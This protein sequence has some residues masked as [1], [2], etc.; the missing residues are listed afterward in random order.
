MYFILFPFVTMIYFIY[1]SKY[2][3]IMNYFISLAFVFSHLK[4]YIIVI[5][6]SNCTL[7]ELLL[8]SY[9]QISSRHREQRTPLPVLLWCTKVYICTTIYILYLCILQQGNS[10][11]FNNKYQSNACEGYSLYA[12]S[13]SRATNVFPYHFQVI[14]ILP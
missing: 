9:T 4:I 12:S 7:Q 6:I 5:M 1:K 8:L 2:S 13:A 11:T 14:S 10:N 3:R